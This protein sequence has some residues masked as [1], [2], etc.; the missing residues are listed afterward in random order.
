[1]VRDDVWDIVWL[2][3]PLVLV[4]I[5]CFLVAAYAERSGRNWRAWFW[6]SFLSNPLIALILLRL[7]PKEYQT[8]TQ[9][10]IWDWS[11]R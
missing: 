4:A 10:D 6:V 9:G 7:F 2:L 8:R 1:M 5:G 11:D 3:A